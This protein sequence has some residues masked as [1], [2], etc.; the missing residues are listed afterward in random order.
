M[1]RV[2]KPSSNHC[3]SL[4]PLV[5][6]EMDASK[7]RSRQQPFATVRVQRRGTR[8]CPPSKP[9]LQEGAKMIAERAG[10]GKGAISHVNTRPVAAMPFASS[11][12]TCATEPLAAAQALVRGRGGLK[13]LVLQR[14]MSAPN[15]RCQQF[16]AD[17]RDSPSSQRTTKFSI[18]TINLPQYDAVQS[19]ERLIDEAS[20]RRSG[21]YWNRRTARRSVDP[22]AIST[23]SGLESCSVCAWFFSFG[24]GIAGRP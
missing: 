23:R 21:S 24:R 13:S 16:Q 11:V 7:T 17:E 10:L 2:A 1:P 3:F 22:V 12:C 5:R 18:D 19:A 20:A 8:V 14:G 9:S 6:T 15:P 4:P